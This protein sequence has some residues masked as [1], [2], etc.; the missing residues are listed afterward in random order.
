M[1][2]EGEYH[3][4]QFSLADNNGIIQKDAIIYPLRYMSGNPNTREKDLDDMLNYIQ[5]LGEKIY[6]E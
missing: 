1:S 5:N 3:L 2:E 4:H 6:N